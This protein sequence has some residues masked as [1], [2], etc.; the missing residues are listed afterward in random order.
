MIGSQRYS[1]KFLYLLCILSS[2]FY[3]VGFS[4]NSVGLVS[5][6]LGFLS[7]FGSLL[8]I[9]AA[10]KIAIPQIS[11]LKDFDVPV[12]LGFL[13][14][15]SLFWVLSSILP[16]L[17]WL[18]PGEIK[19]EL[20]ENRNG[21]S[22]AFV[23]LTAPI[24]FSKIGNKSV[25]FLL[26]VVGG[27]SVFLCL[28]RNPSLIYWLILAFFFLQ[29]FGLGLSVF[30]G[31]IAIILLVFAD[32]FRAGGSEELFYRLA[33][34]DL[35]EYFKRSPELDVNARVFE[36]VASFR[37]Y[38]FEK[39]AIL[40]HFQP[41]L[42]L[43]PV[44]YVTEQLA[45]ESGIHFA[46]KVADLFPTRGGASLWI[47]GYFYFGPIGALLWPFFWLFVLILFVKIF[48]G[49][50]PGFFV[51]CSYMIINSNRIDA[52]TIINF[53][54]NGTLLLIVFVLAF[55]FVGLFRRFLLAA[56]R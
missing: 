39:M 42:G 2:F 22:F 20:Y 53:A 18:A 11:V 30:G 5:I 4:A 43:F 46:R 9:Y 33:N 26:L 1:N 24:L 21:F 32:M 54:W 13:L 6:Y 48:L 51:V 35:V 34:T 3:G 40:D 19:Y 29:R 25:R 38:I 45:A 10:S 17:F 56:L 28:G 49:R 27:V 44:S 41:I 23:I 12:S 36:Y 37:L 50:S 7:L 14:C 16:P 15:V 55:R 52:T 31:L 8:A 47:E